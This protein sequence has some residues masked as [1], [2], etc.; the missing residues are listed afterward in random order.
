M[1]TRCLIKIG[2]VGTGGY[3]GNKDWWYTDETLY[4]HWD[5]HP[6]NIIPLLKKC[7]G[8][9]NKLLDLELEDSFEEVELEFHE[10]MGASYIYYIDRCDLGNIKCSVVQSD[11]EY[12]MKYGL[13]SYKLVDELIL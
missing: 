2:R 9:A 8:D 10:D 13:K 3:N 5:G 1:A 11:L 6:E 4:K 12:S 7:K